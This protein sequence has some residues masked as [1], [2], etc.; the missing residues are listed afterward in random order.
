MTTHEVDELS[1]RIAEGMRAPGL[2]PAR[3]FLWAVV[4]TMLGLL[5]LFG[6]GHFL[7]G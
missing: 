4:F 5:G 6:L 1:R 3:G 7:F 2:K